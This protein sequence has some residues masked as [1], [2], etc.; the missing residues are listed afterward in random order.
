M[1]KKRIGPRGKVVEFELS[2]DIV[3]VLEQDRNAS[4]VLLC[5]TLFFEFYPLFKRTPRI[6]LFS[7]CCSFTNAEWW[8]CEQETPCS[9][10]IKQEEKR[11][12]FSRNFRSLGPKHYLF[13]L[14][15]SNS[16]DNDKR[17]KIVWFVLAA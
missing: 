2:S 10:P 12:V 13:L 7:I 14:T 9:L 3:V 17:R 15:I 11:A 16:F 5:W 1:V 4:R 6:F 8:Q